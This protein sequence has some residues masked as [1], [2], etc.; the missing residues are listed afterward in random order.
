METKYLEKFKDATKYF[1]LAGN[2]ILVER[3]D[4]AE[5][6]TRGGLI[7]AESPK[8]NSE[9][10]SHKPL[11]CMVL[12]VGEGYTDPEADSGFIPTDVQPGNVVVL[13]A[14]G[15]SFF[16]VVPGVSSFTDMKLGISSEADVQMRFDSITDFEEYSKLMSEAFGG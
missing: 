13:N 11:V 5:V 4:A 10:K 9:L 15:V 2:R 3:M 6:K 7:I 14:L 1:T 12:A 16:S 8:I